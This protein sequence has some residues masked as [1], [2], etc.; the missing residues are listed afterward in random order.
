MGA[1]CKV[2]LNPATMRAV[3]VMVAEGLS[4]QAI[5]DRVGGGI[6]RMSVQRHR[7]QHIERPAKAVAE[8][9][10]RG[11]DAAAQRAATMT[12]AAAGDPMAF[13]GLAA[14]V[15]DLKRVRDRL[16]RQADMAEQ[17]GQG[18]AV[19][20]LAGQ[21][22]RSAEVR[23]KLGQVGGYAPHSV[24]QGAAG[25]F[26]LTINLGGGQSPETITITPAP[27]STPYE[28]ELLPIE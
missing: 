2:C 27:Q 19:A 20:A 6:G 26:S 15:D 21:Q 16:E 1:P 11:A 17:A 23:S 8:M 22:L 3:A 12:A 5:S 14:I 9:A 7:K 4:D 13:I 24:A 25:A 18:A 10:N 28:A